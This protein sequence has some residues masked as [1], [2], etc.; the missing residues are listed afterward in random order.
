M[1]AEGDETRTVR[2]ERD[3]ADAR[4]ACAKMK[5]ERDALRVLAEGAVSARKE[6][7]EEGREAGRVRAREEAH[8]EIAAH[9]TNTAARMSDTF[10]RD[11]YRY[12]AA[13]LAAG[14]PP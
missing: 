4:A 6:G 8:A 9:L 11:A 13:Q 5:S 7:F 10:Q 14:K 1:D 3:L 2:I 12:I